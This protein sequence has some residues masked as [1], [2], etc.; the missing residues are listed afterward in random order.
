MAVKSIWRL[1]NQTCIN[2]PDPVEAP[3]WNP[4]Y[5]HILNPFPP[6][7][8]LGKI[9]ILMCR[10]LL[11]LHPKCVIQ[12]I[13]HFVTY[14]LKHFAS[15]RLLSFNRPYRVN[16]QK[17]SWNWKHSFKPNL[18]FSTKNTCYKLLSAIYSFS[19]R[20]FYL[21]A[22]II[23]ISRN[24]FLLVDYFFCFIQEKVNLFFNTI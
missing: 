24:F 13:E 11:R 16:L 6:C 12:I 1:F 14:I 8:V 7:A 18:V 3:I 10:G 20:A 19:T 9:L 17:A 15:P 23:I 2:N 22:I 4:P 5:D 21:A